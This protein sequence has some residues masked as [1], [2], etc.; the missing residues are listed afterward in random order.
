MTKVFSPTLTNEAVF[1]YT[2]LYVRFSMRI[3]DKI[4]AQN[5][6]INYK[7]IFNKHREQPDSGAHRLERRYRQPDQSERL[8]TEQH[9]VRRTNGCRPWPTTSPRFGER[10]RRSSA[11]TGSAP[12][13]SSPATTMSTAQQVYAN[14]GQGSTGN[15]YADMLTG[16]M[17][18]V[19][20]N[21]TP[22]R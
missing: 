5:L 2:N 14:W 7:H 16:I 13:T 17:S 8:R 4:N 22:I 1:T 12:R 6:G 3:P 11:S 20:A 19:H 15:A 21:R 9:S 10:T 18:A